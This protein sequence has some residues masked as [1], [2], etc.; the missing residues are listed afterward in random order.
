M[1]WEIFT[2]LLAIRLLLVSEISDQGE[3]LVIIKLA[4][5][6]LFDLLLNPFDFI[7]GYFLA[8]LYNVFLNHDILLC[9]FMQLFVSIVNFI[10][11]VL[12]L[13]YFR[14]LNW[15]TLSQGLGWL[16]WNFMG[17]ALTVIMHFININCK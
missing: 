13:R 9:N 15:N 16:N 11:F 17:A 12:Q 8:C 7:S 1:S 2:Y 3:V 6:F 14:V 10:E 4:C 5:L